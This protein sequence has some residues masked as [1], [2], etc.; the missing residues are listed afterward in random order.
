[1][2]ENS[3]CCVAANRKYIAGNF[4]GAPRIFLADNTD[5]YNRLRCAISRENDTIE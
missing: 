1:M 5:Q 4:Y 3:L 2:N